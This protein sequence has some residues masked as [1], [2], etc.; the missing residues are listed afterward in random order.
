MPIW[1]PNKAEVSL[2]SLKAA[3][4][5]MVKQHA[6][7][8]LQ[9][10]IDCAPLDGIAKE[11]AVEINALVKSH[12][13]VKLK[14]VDLAARYVQ[15]DFTQEMTRLPGQKAQVTQAMDSM[16]DQM[17]VWARAQEA[18]NVAA[19]NVMIADTDYNIQYVNHS[20]AKML[21]EVEG[22]MRA[23]LP[24]FNA[25]TVIGTNIDVFHKSPSHQRNMLGSLRTTHST[26]L[27]IGGRTYT[28]IVNPILDRTGQVR[29]GTVVE[30][31]DMTAE[32]A[33]RAKEQQLAAEN[34]RVKSALD[35]CTT[36]VMIADAESQIVYMN[37]SVHDMLSKAE[38]DLRKQLPQFDSRRV[39]GT[40]F[41]Q[42][43]RNPAHQRNMLGQLRSTHR[44]QIVVGGRT[45]QLVASPV[46][47]ADDL[48]LGT[49]VEWKDRTEEVAVETEVASIVASIV[50]AA[51]QGDFTKRIEVSGKEG[52]LQTL[53]NGINSLLQKSEEGLED[54]ARVLES[55]SRGDLRQKI[56]KEYGG[57]LGQL[58]Q[59]ANETVDRLSQ[60]IA[61]VSEAAHGLAKAS[62]EVSATAHTLSESSTKQAAGVEETSASIEQM[63]A[64]INQNADNAKITDA[65]AMK[66]ASEA[67]EGGEAV[68]A[69]VAAMKQIAQKI[70]IIDDIAYQTNLLALNAAIEA[71]RAGEHGKGFAVVAAEVRKLAERSQVA[72]QEVGGVATSSV[73]LAE[74]AGRLL[75]SI[76]PNIKKTSDLVQE[77][78]AASSEQ[79]SGAGQI[80]LAVTQMSQTS[81]QNATSSGELAATAQVLSQQ[82]EHLQQ[83][84]TF[85]T[86]SDATVA[87]VLTA[88]P[89]KAAPAR[90]SGPPVRNAAA[91]PAASAARA[92]S[93][94]TTEGP[95]D[96]AL[97]KRY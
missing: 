63:A 59:A 28:L 48:R 30:W 54:V 52:F 74:K 64:S 56:V 27:L 16:R 88:T 22:D 92:S 36:N 32:L 49:V 93:A 45:F 57:T 42:F 37:Q 9:D 72:A 43:H 17:K 3:L 50:A 5:Q 2:T 38:S 87:E 10:Y 44:T 58:K 75:D 85:F 81:E 39:L 94:P 34:A 19:T 67:A 31:K 12:I 33:A 24:N 35:S 18:L 6:E 47:G 66:A 4:A 97:F 29:I 53:C 70:S 40:S 90:R 11:I 14:V 15:G 83:L 71:A 23:Q 25:K 21:T 65:T 79:T 61:D 20:L 68:R 1:G 8:S 46:F 76:V 7:G 86:I 77:I 26:R 55:M 80:N 60:T 62:E 73:E 96:T 41:D 78:S 91:G 84:M 89:G 82:A 51:A 69:T 95:V 13:D